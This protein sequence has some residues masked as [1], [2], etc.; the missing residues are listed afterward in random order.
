MTDQYAEG[1]AALEEA[2]ECRRSF[3]DRTGEGAA[4]SLL[5]EFLWCPGRTTEAERSARDAVALLEEFLP[6]RELA[7]AYANLAHLCSAA[8]RAQ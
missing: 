7:I 8:R 6:G 5:S 1:I 3:G 2:V 4:L